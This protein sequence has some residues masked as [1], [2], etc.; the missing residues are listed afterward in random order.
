[1]SGRVVE[2]MEGKL[3][4]LCQRKNVESWRRYLD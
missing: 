2:A 3:E 1:M 4:S